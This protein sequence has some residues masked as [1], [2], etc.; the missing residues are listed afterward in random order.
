MTPDGL[1]I[2]VEGPDGSGKTTQAARLV[3]WL[4]SQGFD[5]VAVR[6]PGG[7]PPSEA[8]RNVLMDHTW[9]GLEE[10]LLFLAARSNLYRSVIQPAL[11]AGKIVVADRFVD[12]TRAYQIN[13]RKLGHLTG[14]MTEVLHDIYGTDEPDLVVVL[15]IPWNLAQQRTRR[16]G[17]QSRLDAET[18]EFHARVGAAYRF[19]GA[20]SPNHVLVN[21]DNDPDAVFQDILLHV[22]EILGGAQ[23]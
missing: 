18:A 9:N 22:R 19:I 5:V 8:I 4:R 17:M 11:A 6:E 20:N 1:F 14:I 13:G 3:D 7:T 12:S 23:P 16:R 21:G 2:V 15:D 10:L